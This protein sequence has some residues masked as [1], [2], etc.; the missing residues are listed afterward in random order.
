MDLKRFES[1]FDEQHGVRLTKSSNTLNSWV[2]FGGH[3]FHS[4]I[5]ERAYTS[6]QCSMA[7]INNM[8]WKF[9]RIPLRQ[10]AHDDFGDF[11]LRLRKSLK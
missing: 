2:Q 1:C 8:G 9:F 4:K 10:H 3:V 11:P 7:W 6:W 5:N